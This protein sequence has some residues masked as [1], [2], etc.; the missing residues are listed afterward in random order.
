MAVYLSDPRTHASDY[1]EGNL[2]ER[3]WRKTVHQQ[4]NPE[5]RFWPK[6]KL[7]T[8]YRGQ[9]FVRW[10]LELRVSETETKVKILRHW[11]RGRK[12]SSSHFFLCPHL[13]EAGHSHQSFHLKISFWFPLC[14]NTRI[15]AF[16]MILPK[17]LSEGK[18]VFHFMYLLPVTVNISLPNYTLIVDLNDYLCHL[19]Q[20]HWCVLRLPFT[21]NKIIRN[22]NNK[23]KHTVHDVVMHSLWLYPLQ[24]W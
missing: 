12:A 17:A 15:R 22:G 7:L 11:K 10:E 1:T 16:P 6:R 2:W 23:V 13:F 8:R 4:G 9:S 21:G 18:H 14:R 19:I 20:R 24:Q 5:V 3:H